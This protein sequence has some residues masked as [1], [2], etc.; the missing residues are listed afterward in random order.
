MGVY[1]TEI[2]TSNRLSVSQTSVRPTRG[3]C[4]VVGSWSE[5][6]RVDEQRLRRVP[7]SV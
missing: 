2:S 5:E 1:W 6:D 3:Y 7:L 4:S